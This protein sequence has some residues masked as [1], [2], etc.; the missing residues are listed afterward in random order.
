MPLIFPC[1]NETQ[2]WMFRLFYDSSISDFTS[3]LSQ[4]TDSKMTTTFVI[5]EATSRPSIGL[6]SERWGRW[7]V[8]WARVN[9]ER[10]ILLTLSRLLRKKCI[11]AS[12]ARQKNSPLASDLALFIISLSLNQRYLLSLR[13]LSNKSIVHKDLFRHEEPRKVTNSDTFSRL[14]K[15]FFH[16]LF[17]I[18][19]TPMN[20]HFF[21]AYKKDIGIR[22]GEE[23]KTL[24]K[25]GQ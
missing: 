8:I 18:L 15:I 20:G 12:R 9:H 4:E 14:L 10:E 19:L 7:G 3:V 22:R 1:I 25:T 16:P 13:N 23:V 5:Q 24:S 17:C 2:K 6:V 11:S 21:D